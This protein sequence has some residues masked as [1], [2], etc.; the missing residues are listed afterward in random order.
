VCLCRYQSVQV[1]S[2]YAPLRPVNVAL[3]Y[4][5]ARLELHYSILN[6]MP[7]A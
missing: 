3:V 6:I 2:D 7:S 1:V 4:V 5:A